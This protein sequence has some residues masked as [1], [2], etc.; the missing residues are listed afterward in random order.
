MESLP[1]GRNSN[2]ASKLEHVAERFQ[3]FYNDLEQEKQARL[4]CDAS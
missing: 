4:S 2:A 1:Q 3:A